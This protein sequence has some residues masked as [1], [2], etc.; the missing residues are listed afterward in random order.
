M[1]TSTIIAVVTTS[2]F[3]GFMPFEANAAISIPG[4]VLTERS[5]SIDL[6]VTLPDSV[7]PTRQF[8]LF[9]VNPSVAA[10]P[11]FAL[12]FFLSASSKSFTGTQ[13][14][15]GIG[16]GNPS[17]GDY[18]YVIFSNGLS[19]GESVF[20]RLTATWSSAAFDPSQVDYLDV[21]WGNNDLL[22]ANPTTQPSAITGGTYLTTVSTVPEPSVLGLLVSGCA[23]ALGL[24]RK[25]SRRG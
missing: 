22:P 23:L 20:G 14:L 18:F 16:T 8:A 5:F 19:S 21:Y 25:R 6:S 13:T 17:N 10:N 9:F 12:G 2:P 11:G 1:K 15:G 24:A 4:L 3:L 7:P